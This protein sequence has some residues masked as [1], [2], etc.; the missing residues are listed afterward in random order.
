MGL[1][2]KLTIVAAAAL[3]LLAFVIP[4]RGAPAAPGPDVSAN[5]VVPL[6]AQKDAG[7]ATDEPGSRTVREEIAVPPPAAS[8]PTTGALAVRVIY[9]ADDASLA[10]VGV[11]VLD[12]GVVDRRYC[13]RLAGAYASSK[14]SPARRAQ[15][16]SS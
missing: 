5:P 11:H 10:D 3:A 9:G 13:T 4:W 1:K 12:N 7:P 15:S 14:R 6:V 2:T 16:I 8:G